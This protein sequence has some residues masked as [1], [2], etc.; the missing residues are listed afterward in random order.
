MFK[1]IVK[2]TPI[3]FVIIQDTEFIADRVF[4][5]LEQFYEDDEINDYNLNEEIANKLVAEGILTMNY[6]SRNAKIY[7]KTDKFD[8]F[9]D[10]FMNNYFKEDI[11]G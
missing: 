9:H 6:G 4:E 1:F 5:I 8:K 3:T 11:G 7:Y 10:E 2:N